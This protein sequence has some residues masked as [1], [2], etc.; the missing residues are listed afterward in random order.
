MSI[1]CRCPLRESRLYLRTSP[2]RKFVNLFVFKIVLYYVLAKMSLKLF[3]YYKWSGQCYC[4]SGNFWT[5]ENH[6]MTLNFQWIYLFIFLQADKYHCGCASGL[7]CRRYRG[8]RY[9]GKC[10]C[11]GDSSCAKTHCCSGGLCKPRKKAGEYC[12]LKG[13]KTYSLSK[14][15]CFDQNRTHWKNKPFALMTSTLVLRP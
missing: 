11:S 9:W 12:P 4:H 2:R 10:A 14:Y 8:N 1:L 6:P 13:V 5:F 15:F 7:E 3:S